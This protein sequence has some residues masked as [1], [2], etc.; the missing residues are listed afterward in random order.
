MRLDSVIICRNATEE[1]GAINLE[2]IGFDTYIFNDFP[3]RTAIPLFIRAVG[4][5]DTVERHLL[6]QTWDAEG[7]KQ[8]ESIM[9]IRFGARPPDLPEKWEVRVVKLFTLDATFNEPG[10]YL[11]TVLIAGSAQHSQPIFIRSAQQDAV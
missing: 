11:L 7:E 9:P 10:V 6:V 4:V 1:D 3:A 2:G 5:H 8:S